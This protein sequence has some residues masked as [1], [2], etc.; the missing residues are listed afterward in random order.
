[1]RLRISERAEKEVRKLGKVSQMVVAKKI[2]GLVESNDSGLEKL[3][4]FS[5][6]YRVRVGD[7]R[8]VYRE[9]TEEIFVILVGHRM[10]IFKRVKQLLD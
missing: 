3:V 9:T 6:I 7:Y 5:G 8:I 2:R 4:G 10:D 1:M